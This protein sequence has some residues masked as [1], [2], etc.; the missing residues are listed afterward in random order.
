MIELLRAWCRG[1]ETEWE[2]EIYIPLPII[3]LTVAVILF[4][5]LKGC[6]ET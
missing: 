6:L 5:V 4:F 3:L 1:E 2:A